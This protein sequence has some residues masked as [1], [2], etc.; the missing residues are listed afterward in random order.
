MLE[1]Q[2]LTALHALS[3][4]QLVGR[5]VLACYARPLVSTVWRT[6]A[7]SLQQRPAAAV[8]VHVAPIQHQA[9]YCFFSKENY[10]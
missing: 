3:P 4:L 8:Q 1:L 5:R 2:Q 9:A 6:D 7:Y 10:V